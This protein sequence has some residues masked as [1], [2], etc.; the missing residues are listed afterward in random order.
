ML[1]RLPSLMLAEAA[2][3]LRYTCHTPKCKPQVNALVRAIAIHWAQVEDLSGLC[4]VE[5]VDALDN[6]ASWSMQ[7]F[8]LLRRLD[9][10]LVEREVELKYTG[11]VMLWVSATRSLAN[12]KCKD[13][14]W[15]LRALELCR[16]KTFADKVS[17]FQQ[18][19]L[20]ESF[21]KLSLFD[22]TA[23]RNLAEL[24]LSEASL[25]KELKD[26]APVAW[27][28]ASMGFIH[29]E[30][31]DA[32]YI[33]IMEMFEAES[34]DMSK[35][36]T[37]IAVTQAG[38]SFAVAGYHRQYESF[39][40]FLDYV[41]WNSS[42]PAA[43]QRLRAEL[44]EL[45]VTEVPDVVALCQC[46]DQVK[47]AAAEPCTRT[48]PE[49]AQLP[50][51]RS[52]VAAALQEMGWNYSMGNAAA[53][54]S[55]EGRQIEYA[56]VGEEG[57]EPVLLFYPLGACRFLAAVFATPARRAGARLICLNRPGMGKASPAQTGNVSDH[58]AAH[59]QDAVK[60]LDHL[61]YERARVLFLCAGAPFALAFQARYPAR[62]FGRLV[63][64]S[65]WVS[66]LDCPRAK[67]MYRLSASLPSTMLATLADAVAGWTR[68]VPSS[69][70]FSS[71]P[72][73]SMPNSTSS[74]TQ[75]FQGPQAVLLE[76]NAP[77]DSQAD[78]ALLIDCCATLANKFGQETGGEGA[79][80]ATLVESSSAWGVDYSSLDCSLVLLHGDEDTTV[81]VECIEW[82]QEKIPQTI[83]HRI[84]GA[85]HGDTMLLGI[86][87]ALRLLMPQKAL[88]A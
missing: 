75:S 82:L 85:Q 1:E 50:A 72:T 18:C 14:T 60:C 27:A 49:E 44:A 3:C 79:D 65:A 12:M 86:S 77:E 8:D 51:F 30:L 11:N 46:S 45:S 80:A 16:D 78:L 26:I 35:R 57:A 31:L 62:T 76:K 73:S 4:V 42:T 10:I 41:F 70:A 29:K 59:C 71:L 38:W 48:G 32:L 81:P 20:I 55:V 61:G 63:G 23:Y 56:L 2:S 13:A 34:L 88:P 84:P 22:D 39:S 24:L 58:I 64:C 68:A 5:V 69:T 19:T 7:P 74:M 54:S 33:R 25:F 43:A 66:P 36:D 53:D 87:A 6:F 37:N 83:V 15:P 40:S 9:P 21:A 52:D 67:L 17:F 47:A 28:A